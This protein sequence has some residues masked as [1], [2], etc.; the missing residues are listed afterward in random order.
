MNPTIRPQIKL[1]DEATIREVL[2]EAKRILLE[3]GFFLENREALEI[4]SAA[5]SS[6]PRSW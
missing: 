3:L 2:T 5:G 6:W 1:L 4:L